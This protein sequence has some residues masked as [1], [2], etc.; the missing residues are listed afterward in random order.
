MSTDR[1]GVIRDEWTRLSTGW[2]ER[3][4]YLFEVSRPVHDWL[5]E[6]L[7][8]SEGESVLEIGAGTGDTG[9]LAAPRLGARGKLVSTDLSPAMVEVSRRRAAELAIENAEFEAVDAQAMP[10]SG[11]SF[12]GAISRWGYMLMPDPAAALR[13]THRVLKPGGRL[14]F[15]VFT[16]PA[17]NQWASLPVRL[18]VEGGQMP[19]PTPG[20]PGILALADRTRL[21]GLVR[22]AGFSSLETER[23]SFS[24]RFPDLDAYWS[25]LLEV[26]ALGPAMQSLA[27]SAK[28]YLRQRLTEQLKA[29]QRGGEIELPAQ[30]WMVRAVR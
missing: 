17:E 15:A 30:C 29:F 4:A 16:A 27:P 14:V 21:E 6:K 1:T 24:W 9:F 23:V 5:I 3:R 18:L 8:P 11:A 2:E 20:A 19:A 10:F 26:T 25:F 22:D 12:D 28:E 13:E 7:C